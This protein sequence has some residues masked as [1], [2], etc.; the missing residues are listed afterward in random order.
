MKQYTNQKLI[1]MNPVDEFWNNK[2]MDKINRHRILHCRKVSKLGIPLVYKKFD[3]YVLDMFM[4]NKKSIK[5]KKYY[6]T[7]SKGEIVLPRIYRYYIDQK[8]AQN[9]YCT[10][11]L[12]KK[13]N[14]AVKKAIKIGPGIK[15]DYMNNLDKA[16]TEKQVAKWARILL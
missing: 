13:Y 16:P 3:D 5:G 7:N 9:F 14:D 10:E 12:G 8:T 4:Y 15:I 1:E 6:H 11:S 2:V